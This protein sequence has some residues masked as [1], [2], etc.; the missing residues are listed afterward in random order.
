MKSSERRYPMT[1]N[2]LRKILDF[3][4]AATQHIYRFP[5]VTDDEL[6]FWM[7][8]LLPIKEKLECFLEAHRQGEAIGPMKKIVAI[9]DDDI[10]DIQETPEINHISPCTQKKHIFANQ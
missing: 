4:P 1:V 9:T 10:E 8:A 3:I 5:M 6:H 7:Q 2:F